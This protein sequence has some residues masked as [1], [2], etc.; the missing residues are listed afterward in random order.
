M[1]INYELVKRPLL[2][3]SLLLVVGGIGV[4]ILWLRYEQTHK[5]YMA[6]NTE[7]DAAHARYQRAEAD[8]VLFQQYKNQFLSYQ[9]QGVIGQEN[10]LSWAE[11]LHKQD[12]ALSLPVFNVQIS[13]R[14]AL[15][16]SST[17]AS[18]KWFKSVQSI[19]ADL[20]HEG[21]LLQILQSL[22]KHAE[23]LFRVAS[24]KL[25]RADEIQLTPQA[26]NIN[27]D[28]ILHWYS[29]Q[30]VSPAEGYRVD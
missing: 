5:L 1:I 16:R 10:R 23:G 9:D 6:A 2:S 29:L 12:L 14:Q 15:H 28:C 21:D 26:A 7:R 18:I 24:C 3:L 22:K 17:P 25:T 13:P 11:I 30:I 4:S 8:L 19:K 20:L 27:A